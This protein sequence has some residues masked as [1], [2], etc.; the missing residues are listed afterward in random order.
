MKCERIDTGTQT[1]VRIEGSLDA[2]T[3]TE[4]RPLLDALVVERR[5]DIVFDLQ[6]LSLIDSSG[7]GAIVALF[8]RVKAYR[9]VVRVT[10]LRDQPLA[11]FRLLRLDR[12]LAT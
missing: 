7:V 5:L 4:L 6:G 3:A 8:K 9:G 12:I 11:I 2:L 10:G 1:L